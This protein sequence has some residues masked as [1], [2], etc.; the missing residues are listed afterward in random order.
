MIKKLLIAVAAIVIM[1]IAAPIIIYVGSMVVIV[2]ADKIEDGKY[3]FSNN[4]EYSMSSVTEKTTLLP[5]QKNYKG[6]Y[7]NTNGEVVIKPHYKKAYPFF[8]NRAIVRLPTSKGKR[9]AYI[10]KTGSIIWEVKFAGA[11][12]FRFLN[13]RNRF[14]E[15]LAMVQTE[16]KC[17]YIDTAGSMVIEEQFYE[18]GIFSE[19][20][21]HT[22]KEMH[23]LYGYIDITGN[24]VIEPQFDRAN[25]FNDGLARVH[26][27]NRD[28]FI[29]PW[30]N[31]VIPPSIPAATDFSGG[32]ARISSDEEDPRSYSQFIDKTGQFAFQK[33]LHTTVESRFYEGLAVASPQAGEDWGYIDITGEFIIQPIFAWAKEFSGGLAPVRPTWGSQWGYIDRTGSMVIKPQFSTAGRFDDGIAQVCKTGLSAGVGGENCGYINTKGEYIWKPTS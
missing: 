18:C 21:A 7:I 5:I 16:E 15:G 22:R 10:T 8:N 4:A 17:G 14:S 2:V 23:G 32:Y 11:H 9:F 30:G 6:G 13:E 28:G 1:F 29:D 12:S 19:G 20:M 31:F 25:S 27:N 26:L 24:F 3:L 33:T